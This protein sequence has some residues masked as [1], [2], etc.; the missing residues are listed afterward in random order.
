MV[1]KNII[2]FYIKIAFF[3]YFS[4]TLLHSLW[5]L[6]TDFYGV[7]VENICFKEADTQLYKRWGNISI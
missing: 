4:Y 1:E 5:F 3:K 7:C 2:N 6:W